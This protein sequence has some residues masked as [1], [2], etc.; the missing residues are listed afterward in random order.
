MDRLAF[1][2]KGVKQHGL[3]YT[4]LSRVKDINSLYLLSKLQQSN[5]SISN[6]A[7]VE[8]KRLTKEAYYRHEYGLQSIQIDKYL[9]ICSLNTRSLAL[10]IEHISHDFDILNSSILCF[11][12]TQKAS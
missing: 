2:P 4:A 3:V 12:E 1:D 11:Q 8:M 7:L 9:V 6:K 5:F 10:H